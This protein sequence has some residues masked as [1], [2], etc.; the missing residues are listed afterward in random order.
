MG[1][2][3]RWDDGSGYEAYVGRWSRRVAERFLPWLDVARGAHWVDVG[4]GTGELTRAI[5]VL[6]APES[7]LSI[8]PSAGFLARA[9]LLTRDTRAEFVEGT[10]SRLPVRDGSAGAAV[11]G[12]VLN[13]VPD[14]DA[15]LGEMRRAVVPGGIVG[16]YVWDYGGE[17]Q[18]MRRFWDAAIELD[19][20]AVALDEGLRFPL[21]QEAGLAAAFER[22]GLAEIEVT[23][24]D[25]PT[26]FRDFEDYWAPF[27]T[28]V[29]PAPGYAVSL[30][31]EARE[32]L[33]SRLEATLPREPDGSI[34]LIA[35]AWAAKGRRPEGETA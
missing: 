35:R 30:E 14:V 16:G 24:I 12:L 13:F 7:V 27:L 21:A 6:Q 15:A 31:P 5:L 11:A 10:A 1:A 19:P 20:G 32:R 23:A 28:G 9:R 8:D 34:A 29:A 22:A 33:R 2:M 25:I 4:C 17:M 3:D 26:I 18:L